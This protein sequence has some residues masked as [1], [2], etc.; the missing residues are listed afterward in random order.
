MSTQKERIYNSTTVRYTDDRHSI[1][2]VQHDDWKSSGCTHSKC[3]FEL[4][5]GK[6]G[7]PQVHFIVLMAHFFFSFG[8]FDFPDNWKKKKKKLKI[9]PGE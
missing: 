1:I 6:K 5:K 8:C 2:I 7:L 3:D 4:D 9:G